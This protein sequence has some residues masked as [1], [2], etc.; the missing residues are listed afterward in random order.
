MNMMGKK[1]GQLQII[2]M[3]IGELVPDNHL[4]RK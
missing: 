4:L 3:D 2:M 1:D